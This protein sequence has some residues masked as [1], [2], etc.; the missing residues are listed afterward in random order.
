[1]SDTVVVVQEAPASVVVVQAEPSA[2]TVVVEAAPSVIEVGTGLRGPQGPAGADSV[3]PGPQ[4][5]QGPQGLQGLQGPQGVQGPAGA[6]S[7]VP[8]P[9]GEDGAQGPQG[10]QGPA[11]A[12]STVPGPKGDQGDPGTPG[13]TERKFTFILHLGE[14][15]VVG[16]NKTNAL[17][18]PSACTITK[19]FAYAKV[20]PTG[21][22]II[23]D[24]NRNGSTIWSTQANRITIAAAANAGS[25]T[26]FNT[27]AL[28]EGDLLT[29]D[30]DQV[31]SILPGQEITVTLRVA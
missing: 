3:V 12:A 26:A 15:A 13:T 27:T 19:V 25:Q 16:N 4:G 24:I 5:V 31:G 21:A 2:I 9:K 11:G 14:D 20:A 1:V 22:A 10:I 17:V 7:T 23:M 8:G 6:A 28:A 30:I 18:V 29:I